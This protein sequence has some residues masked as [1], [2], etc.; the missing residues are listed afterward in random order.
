MKK[1]HLGNEKI[2]KNYYKNYDKLRKKVKKLLKYCI[3]SEK[4]H[5]FSLKIID[6]LI[7]IMI[8]RLELWVLSKIT[9]FS[10]KTKPKVLINCYCQCQTNAFH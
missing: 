9:N 6:F 2:S 10:S 3:N 7:K 4:F 8:F 5:Q 1:I